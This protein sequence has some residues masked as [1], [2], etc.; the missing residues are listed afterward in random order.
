MKRL[1]GL[2]AACAALAALYSTSASADIVYSVDLISG[3]TS[4][5][6]QITTDGHT[7]TLSTGDILG[8]DV[9]ISNSGGSA[10]LTA[11]NGVN[12]NFEDL[13][14]SST[15]LFYNFSSSDIASFF[16][17]SNF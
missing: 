9:V 11:L 1:I 6:G 7:G 16:F 8:I 13:T 12:V 14:A 15:D 2:V 17:I 10:T 5:V 4:V 3:T